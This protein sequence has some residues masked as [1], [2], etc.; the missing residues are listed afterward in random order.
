MQKN[1]WQ[2]YS[3][4]VQQIKKMIAIICWSAYPKQYTQTYAKQTDPCI[5]FILC[6]L[7]NQGAVSI[8]KTVLPGMA[9]SM[10]KI[11]RPNGRLIFNME[12]AIRR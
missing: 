11:R 4:E 3:C 7:Q 1:T 8:R 12:I 9:I 2:E 5:I 10:L 6:R